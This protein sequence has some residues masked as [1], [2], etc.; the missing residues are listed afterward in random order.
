[1]LSGILNFEL[2]FLYFGTFLW[3]LKNYP[4]TRL[5]R[6]SGNSQVTT[7]DED[8]FKHCCCCCCCSCI[9]GARQWRG[10]R[11]RAQRSQHCVSARDKRRRQSKRSAS[12]LEASS[13]S[14]SFVVVFASA[15][16]E[17]QE[18][19][20]REREEK[21]CESEATANHEAR[22][23]E[24]ARS[25]SLALSL[26]CASM[27]ALSGSCRRRRRRQ[28]LRPRV[29]LPLPSFRLS[30]LALGLV[31]VAAAITSSTSFGSAAEVVVLPLPLI[32]IECSGGSA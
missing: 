11:Q 31:V 3:S 32:R 28:V 16:A 20:K 27:V 8:P 29:L 30:P 12:K 4:D 5:I 19:G 23:H 7:T 13:S 15:N 9:S 22:N 24:V 21:C 17:R 10:A 14:S 6:A 25:V 1:M 26:V 18:R 2:L